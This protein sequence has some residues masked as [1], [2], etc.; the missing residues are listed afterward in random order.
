MEDPQGP[1]GSFICNYII[2][3]KF[4]KLCVCHTHCVAE[5]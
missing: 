5:M 2:L 4:G 3:S 1:A